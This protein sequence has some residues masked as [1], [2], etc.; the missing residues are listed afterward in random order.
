[1]KTL[2]YEVLDYNKQFVENE[3][4][5]P[6]LTSKFP[7]KKFVIITCM[8]TRLIELLPASMDIK[9]GDVKIIKIAGAVVAHPFGSVMRSIIVAIYELKASE[10]F[11]VGH[12]DCGMGSLDPSKMKEK[13]KAEG[14]KDETIKTLEYYGLDLEK[15]LKGFDDVNESVRNSVKL[16][17][18][19]PL[20][21]KIAVHG[22]VISP[23]TGKLDVVEDGYVYLEEKEKIQGN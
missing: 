13:F 20:L 1:M 15:W 16:I 3:K 22:L 11:I 21:P 2:L 12:T 10:V 8:D 9:N 4:Y 17:R 6:F 23:N 19:H 18:N 5:I 14:I 7:E